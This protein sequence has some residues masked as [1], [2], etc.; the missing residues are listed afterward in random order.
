VGILFQVR[1]DTIVPGFDY[2]RLCVRIPRFGLTERTRFN[3]DRYQIFIFSRI[4]LLNKLHRFTEAQAVEEWYQTRF[5]GY[6]L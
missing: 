6:R 4:A 2:A 3:L 5:K 1:A